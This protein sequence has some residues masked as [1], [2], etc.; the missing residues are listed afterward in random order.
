M[1]VPTLGG[2]IR[3]NPCRRDAR[4]PPATQNLVQVVWDTASPFMRVALAMAKGGI[5]RTITRTA[6]PQLRFGNP[7]RTCTPPVPLGMT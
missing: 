4:Q 2:L 7:I 6:A 1:I 5:G 3:Q